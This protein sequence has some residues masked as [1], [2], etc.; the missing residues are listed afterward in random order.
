MGD[1]AERD[2]YRI[3]ELPLPQTI[4]VD[5]GA[6]IGVFSKRFHQRNPLARIFALECCPE[7]IPALKK[8]VGD[9][10]TVIQAAVTYE[11]DVALLSSVFPHCVS[12]GG[13]AV[14]GRDA[15]KRR[16]QSGELCQDPGR[17]MQGEYW[18]DLR[19]LKTLTLE[20][21]LRAYD[22]DRI[23]VLKLDCEG[24][25]FSILGNTSSLDRIG[26][27]LGEY[28]GKE[29]FLKLVAARF[30][31]WKLRMLSDGP[32]GNFWLTRQP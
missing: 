11:K 24:S 20:A 1:I 6:H 26:V 5:V 8:N 32:L 31:A 3:D 27:I 7:N 23:D 18:A 21:I 25:E 17:R 13:S 29:E 10:A 9:F 28:H 22:L 19:P 12:T 15:L 14:L 4:V 30:S 2:A 16:I